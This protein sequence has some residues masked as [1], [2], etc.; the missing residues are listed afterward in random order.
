MQ[1]RENFLKEVKKM[2]KYLRLSLLS[3]ILLISLT[4]ISLAEE[5]TDL[6]LSDLIKQAPFFGYAFNTEEST[7]ISIYYP[8]F[9]YQEKIN[10]LTVDFEKIDERSVSY[11]F[12]LDCPPFFPLKEVEQTVLTAIQPEN[13]SSV[14]LDTIFTFEKTTG[15]KPLLKKRGSN[16]KKLLDPHWNLWMPK[17]GYVPL[18]PGERE[19]SMEVALKSYLGQRDAE[20]RRK[21]AERMAKL[22]QRILKNES[23]DDPPEEIPKIPRIT[24]KWPHPVVLPD[25][26]FAT[27]NVPFI[28][29]L[30]KEI[31]EPNIINL[32]TMLPFRLDRRKVYFYV[33]LPTHDRFGVFG[34][35]VLFQY[36]LVLKEI[37]LPRDLPQLKE[38]Y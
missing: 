27:I 26:S 4:T 22:I 14:N 7:Y 24:I 2:R 9:I 25:Q 29:F 23:P 3:L 21:E 19:D 18:G 16:L 10:R 32:I 38:K 33:Y 35:R 30:K 28:R 5:K 6:D 37:E 1:H 13:S 17:L 20:I 34:N 31:I 12:K 11:G 15:K 36:E 8:S